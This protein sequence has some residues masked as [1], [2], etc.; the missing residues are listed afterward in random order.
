MKKRFEKFIEEIIKNGDWE[1]A[2]GTSMTEDAKAFLAWYR[3]LERMWSVMCSLV[4][5]EE[6]T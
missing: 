1:Y 4:D 3:L 5:E 2:D 6:L